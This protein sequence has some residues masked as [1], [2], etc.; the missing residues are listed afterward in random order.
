M[1]NTG[2]VYI[3]SAARTAIGSFNGSLS[4]L[5]AS[6][7]GS[8]VIKEVLKRSKVKNSDVDEVIIGQSLTAG[9]GQNPARQAALQAGLPITVP[10]YNINMLC[11]SGLKTVALGYQSIR[12]GDSKIVICGGQESMSMA[13][14]VIHLRN[15]IKMGAGT[16]LDTMLHDGLTDAMHNI[17]MGVTAE[18]LVKQY[19][20]TR[21][22]QDEYAVRSQN[23]AENAQKNGFFEKEIVP[24]EMKTRTGTQIFDKDEYIK[25]GT[26]ME[27]L[28]KLKPVFID[29]G[30]VTAGNASGINDAAALV[31][32]MSGAEVEERSIKPMAKIVAWAQSGVEPDVMG[33]GPVTAVEAVLLKAGWSKEEVDLFELNEAFAGQ[34]IAV[35]KGLNINS[36]KVNVNG[37]AIALGHPIGASGCRILVT[38]LYALERLNVK[39]GVASLCIGGGMGIAMAIER[40]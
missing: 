36:D 20:L 14:H 15:G 28:K 30:S 24:V 37:G 6:E 31:L 25:T 29:N 1:V 11:G 13:P 40:V 12:A 2:D 32:L 35:L 10:A 9:Q 19:S 23:L 4:K 3:V 38:L 33:I 26:T 22:E 16:M 21:S 17:H 8:I 27:L 39:K 18:N 34:S 5:K 7:L